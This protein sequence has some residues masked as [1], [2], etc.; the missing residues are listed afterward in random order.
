M[1]VAM[2]RHFVLFIPLAALWAGPSAAADEKT[3]A[4]AEKGDA[5]KDVLAPNVNGAVCFSGQFTGH[6][7]HV[8]DYLKVKY[9]PEPAV[10]ENGKQVMRPVPAVYLNQDVRALTLLLNRAEY[11]SRTA[12]ELHNFGLKVSMR[13]WRG[14]L[15]AS[16]DCFWRASDKPLQAPGAVAPASSSTLSCAVHC[17]GGSIEVQRIAGS[18][19]IIFR[20][21]EG[22][23]RMS[24]S[25]DSEGDYHVG[26]PAK[27]GDDVEPDAKES[28]VQFR[29][30]PMPA[31]QCEAFRK[32][33]EPKTAD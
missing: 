10:V 7:V 20:F 17:D 15:Y 9:V 13:G 33:A 14:P 2:L 24:G 11:E 19:E 21:Q 8:H 25:W 12:D 27:P 5:I 1:T 28:P 6:K 22:G 23:L 18:R 29:L 4:P 31:K 32:A 16:G 26:A 30:A 3:A